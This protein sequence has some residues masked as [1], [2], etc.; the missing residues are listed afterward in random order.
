MA[1]T[2][3][4]RRYASFDTISS[5]PGD[6]IDAFWYIIDHQLKGVFLMKTVINFQLINSGGLLSIRFSQD[7]DPTTVTVDFDYPF[8]RRWPTLFHA[9]D[10]MGRETIVTDHEL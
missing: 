9:V 6:V 2:N 4:R 5:I 7:D 1:F 8:N 10:N 3:T